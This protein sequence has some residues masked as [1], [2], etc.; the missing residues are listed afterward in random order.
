MT[1]SIYAPL[2]QNFYSTGR[3]VRLTYSRDIVLFSSHRCFLLLIV[4][5]N[6]SA[7]NGC[8]PSALI[9]MA[10]ESFQLGVS[11]FEILPFINKKHC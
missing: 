3:A 6:H 1:K 11:P 4:D 8:I 2:I 7:A 9:H 10:T 5:E